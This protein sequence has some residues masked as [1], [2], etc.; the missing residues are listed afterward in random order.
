MLYTTV[1]PYNGIHKTLLYTVHPVSMGF[2][3]LL[4]EQTLTEYLRCRKRNHPFDTTRFDV[5]PTDTIPTYH[6]SSHDAPAW[7]FTRWDGRRSLARSA[8][9]WQGPGVVCTTTSIV[10]L[11]CFFITFVSIDR[12]DFFVEVWQ[13]FPRRD[14]TRRRRNWIVRRNHRWLQSTPP[15][16]QLIGGSWVG[17]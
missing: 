8:C 2:G 15:G 14:A 16:H 12:E 13:S 6:A 4:K 3:A 9:S 11:K 1:H 5:V 17:R 7:F 10:A